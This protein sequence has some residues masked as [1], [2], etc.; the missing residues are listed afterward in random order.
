MTNFVFP[1]P[2]PTTLPAANTDASFPVNRVYCIG[3]NYSWSVD[4][5]RPSEMPAW[6]MK[7][8]SAVFEARGALP[9]PPGT[10]DF[11]PR[12]R[13][14]RRHRQGGRNIDPAQVE[15]NHIWGYAAGLT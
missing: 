5:T 8:A 7:P 4:E 10:T 14:G 3:R 11:C 15:A 12:D 9:Y 13:T 6:F 2:A 1:P